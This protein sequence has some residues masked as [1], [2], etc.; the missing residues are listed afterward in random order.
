MQLRRKCEMDGVFNTV[1]HIC[2]G[3]VR[4]VKVPVGFFSRMRKPY[5]E[6]HAL[7]VLGKA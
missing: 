3:K 7:W 1:D 5:C 6:Y 4:W 2:A